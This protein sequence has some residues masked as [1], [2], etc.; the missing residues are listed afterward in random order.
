MAATYN[1]EALATD[2]LSYARARFRDVGGYAD[3]I[4]GR[5]LLQDEEYYGFIERLGDR[6]GL[7]QAAEA[8]A[9]Q[10]AQ[11]VQRYGEAGGI[12]VTWPRRPE[13]YLSLAENI[14]RY[15]VDNRDGSSQVRASAPPLPTYRTD[16]RLALN[17]TVDAIL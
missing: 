6:E 14:R 13:F 17:R 11:R 9:A 5:P 15:G 8:L 1:P 7:A 16:Q 10:Y 4:V 12:D 2:I 3:G